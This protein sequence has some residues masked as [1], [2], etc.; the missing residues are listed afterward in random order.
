MTNGT[1]GSKFHL[2]TGQEFQPFDTKAL[3]VIGQ[4]VFD[5]YQK[6]QAP[7]QN[8]ICDRFGR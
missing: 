6:N 7:F 1:L 8:S 3:N 2:T 5:C 4:Q